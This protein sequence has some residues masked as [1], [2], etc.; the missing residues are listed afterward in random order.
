[1]QLIENNEVQTVGVLNDFRVEG[2]LPRQEQFSHHEV[3]KQNVWRI[4]SDLLTF[5]ST[6]LTGVA[7]YNRPE[8]RG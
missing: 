5:F 6:F 3:G 4:V 8:F 2:V 7:P 1:M